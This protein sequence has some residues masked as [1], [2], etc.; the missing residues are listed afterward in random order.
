MNYNQYLLSFSEFWKTKPYWCQ[1]W[2][3]ILTGIFILWSSWTLLNNMYFSIILSLLIIT[4]WLIFLILAPLT[5]AEYSSLS[6]KQ[7]DNKTL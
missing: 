3:I 4:W 1:P 6:D 5:Y 7:E 2:S